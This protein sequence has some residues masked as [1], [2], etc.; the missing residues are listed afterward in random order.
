[1]PSLMRITK[2]ILSYALEFNIL[3]SAEYITSEDNKLADTQSRVFLNPHIELRLK[4]SVF[5]RI[6]EFFGPHEVDCFAA[7]E[8]H[9]LQR[10]VSWN[11]DPYSMYPNLFSRKFPRGNLYCFPP[12]SLISD[13]LTK[14]QDEEADVTIIVPF[15]KGRPFWPRLLD[16][17]TQWPALLPCPTL[18]APRESSNDPRSSSTNSSHV[19]SPVTCRT[20]GSFSRCD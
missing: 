9:Q 5:R 15:W 13:L 20:E 14:V 7:M 8:N 18:Q 19:V 12:F 17:L 1:M 2:R 16:M 4:P 6:N 11:P 3:I 10:Y